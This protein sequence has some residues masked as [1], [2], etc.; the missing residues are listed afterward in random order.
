M[1]FL[2]S[3]CGISS[4]STSPYRPIPSNC[5][6]EPI[7]A[8]APG[9]LPK[10]CAICLETLSGQTIT[11]PFRCTTVTHL[12]HTK[13]IEHFKQSC[14]D[15][16]VLYV[17]VCCRAPP[18]Y[19]FQDAVVQLGRCYYDN[20]RL[21]AL[22][23]LSPSDV[24]QNAD[25]I[26]S[27]IGSMKNISCWTEAINS[28]PEKM[29]VQ[30]A[31]RLLGDMSKRNFKIN[32][33]IRALEA[34]PVSVLD[35][36]I[37]RIFTIASKQLL[38]HTDDY[39]EVVK[40]LLP[41]VLK[42]DKDHLWEC[43]VDLK[44]CFRAEVILLLPGPFTNMDLVR[45]MRFTDCYVPDSEKQIAILNMYG[46]KLAVASMDLLLDVVKSGFKTPM[47]YEIFKGIPAQQREENMPQILGTLKKIC[48][49]NLCFRVLKLFMP[50]AIKEHVDLLFDILKGLNDE[51]KI[52]E[53]LECMPASFR[54]EKAL[55]I[56]QMAKKDMK[57][58]GHR[59]E[60]LRLLSED[61]QE[62]YANEIQGVLSIID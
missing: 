21:S 6:P 8:P 16:T 39:R 62:K 40:V 51:T 15:S 31:D 17:C 56:I 1:N 32:D 44:T 9:S 49:A 13:C 37:D 35:T 36:N 50:Y 57:L 11:A 47:R 48:D 18:V 19:T 4:S 34:F 30:H 42:M 10:D 3:L 24:V 52:L 12:F 7:P 14:F 33:F 60:V 20:D 2:K 22:K 55:Q 29:R 27:A 59:K 46:P 25:F 61:A 26:L 58:T 53:V 45:I 43:L 54:D 23:S 5:K 38:F 28:L 41:S